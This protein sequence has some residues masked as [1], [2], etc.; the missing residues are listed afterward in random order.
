MRDSV[1]GKSAMTI[2]ILTYPKHFL[3]NMEH[4]NCKRPY[5]AQNILSEIAA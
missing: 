2:C 3:V 1:G 5:V 4:D